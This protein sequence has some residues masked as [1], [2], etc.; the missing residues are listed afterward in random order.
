MELHVAKFDHEDEN[1]LE[2]T[3]IHEGYIKILETFLE[4]KLQDH[5]NEDQVNTFY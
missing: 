5:F 1:K 3:A 2:Y 4:A